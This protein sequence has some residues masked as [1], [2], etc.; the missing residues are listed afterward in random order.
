MS[1]QVLHLVSEQGWEMTIDFSSSQFKWHSTQ[2][3]LPFD[4]FNYNYWKYR[5]RIYLQSINYELWNIVKVTY[6]KPSTPYDQ[7]THD[8]N[9]KKSTNLNAKAMTALFCA[10][11]KNEFNRVSTFTFVHQICHTLQVTHESTNKA[12][13]LKHLFLCTCLNYFKGWKMRRS[14][15]W[16]LDSPI[17]LTL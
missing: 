7:W 13:K 14:H 12:K 2:R 15:K 11:D 8:Q 4:G 5:M 6:E 10:L 3:P 16:L 9:Q 17:S 1:F